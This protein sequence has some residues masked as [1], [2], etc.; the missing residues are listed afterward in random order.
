M[1]AFEIIRVEKLCQDFKESGLTKIV[2]INE[3]K[4]RVTEE[5]QTKF[6]LMT[7]LDIALEKRSLEIYDSNPERVIEEIMDLELVEPLDYVCSSVC[8]KM[9]E[10]LKSGKLKKSS[11]LKNKLTEKRELIKKGLKTYL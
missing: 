6:I 1:K 10:L 5:Y 4:E 8:R 9:K 11:K 7:K 3:N 2:Y